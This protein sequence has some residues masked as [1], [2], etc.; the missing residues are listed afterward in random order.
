MTGVV[1]VEMHLLTEFAITILP[2]TFVWQDFLVGSTNMTR[3]TL[4]L[5]KCARTFVL[6]FV[7][8]KISR[9]SDKGGLAKIKLTTEQQ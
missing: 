3:H 7:K 4:A 1:I 9:V 2:R 5:R 8:K 6:L